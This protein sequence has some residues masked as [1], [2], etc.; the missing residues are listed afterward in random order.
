MA[1]CFFVAEN[2]PSAVMPTSD[3]G[4]AG[5]P[6]LPHSC[7]RHTNLATARLRRE[8]TLFA[9]RLG[10]LDSYDKHRNEGETNSPSPQKSPITQKAESVVGN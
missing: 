2:A 5:A 10:L 6:T 9:Q 3:W 1:G 8:K 7:A 4:T